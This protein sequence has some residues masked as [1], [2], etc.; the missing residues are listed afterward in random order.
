MINQIFI[1]RAGGTQKLSRII[2]I[3][4]AKELI[5]T[6]QRLS[7]LEAL[8]IGI[9]NDV[10]VNEED[11]LQKALNIAHKI[12]KNGPLAVRMAK[13]AINEG[14]EMGLKSGFSSFLFIL[15]FFDLFSFFFYVFSTFEFFF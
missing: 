11:C 2:G 4:K 14:Y 3:A 7:A 5:F 6:S 13:K 9:L 8:N 10:G 15:T 12:A 1:I